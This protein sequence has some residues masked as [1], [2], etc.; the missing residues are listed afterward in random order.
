M[1]VCA[2]VPT[3]DKTVRFNDGPTGR[4]GRPSTMDRNPQTSENRGAH[5]SRT[6]KR[7]CSI[8]HHV[9][10]TDN[11]NR[12][13]SESRRRRLRPLTPP[14]LAAATRAPP[15]PLRRLATTEI[16][17]YLLKIIFFFLLLIIIFI[18]DRRVRR[19][20]TTIMWKKTFENV[21]YNRI[22]RQCIPVDGRK[23]P[24]VQL[25]ISVFEYYG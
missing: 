4:H 14:T 19:R 1:R 23:P 6:E 5:V 18:Y 25:H 13:G 7:V 11:I 9:R 15:P 21:F 10:R 8:A 16:I 2:F 17:T 3:A 12:R 22:R 20:C 24:P